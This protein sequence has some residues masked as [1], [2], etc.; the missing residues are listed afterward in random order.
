[1]TLSEGNSGIRLA[2]FVVTLSAPSASPVTVAYATANGTAT[3]GSAYVAGSGALSFP[4]GQT[5]A[6]ITVSVLGDTAV[7]ANESFLVRLSSAT[8]AT[9]AD[10]VGL[11]TITNDDRTRR[12][13][14][15]R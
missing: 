1:M 9:V 5:S 10:A 2:T 3:A 6:S 12:R 14:R 11:G 13:W 15:R 7:E 8:G 4:A